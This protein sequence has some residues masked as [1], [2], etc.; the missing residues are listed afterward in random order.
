MSLITLLIVIAIFAAVAAAATYFF[1]K[2]RNIFISLLQYFC[3]FLF[4]VSGFVKAVDPLGTA[5]K[6]EDYF[7]QFEFVARESFLSPI[8]SV[9]PFMAHYSLAFSIFTIVLEIMLGIMLV[10][11]SRPKFTAWTF[12]LLIIFF[13]I[14]TGFTYLTGYVPDDVNFFEFTKWGAYEAS[15]MKV[16]D[17]GCFGDF[18]KLEPRISFFKDIFLL[19]P[20]IIFLF[21]FRDFHR[22]FTP[23]VRTTINFTALA[24]LFIF[25]LY[26]SFWAEPIVDFRPFKNGTNVRDIRAAEMK[27][28]NEVPVTMIIKSKKDGKV[29]RLSQDEY[30]KR[31]K[32]FPKEDFE[33]SQEVGESEIPKTKISDFTIMGLDNDDMTESI[34]DEK[35]YSLMFI[36]YHVPYTE[37]SQQVTV[38][39]TI[40][41]K[42]DSTSTNNDSMTIKNIQS[43]IEN[44]S[45]KEWDPAWV[46]KFKDYI[47]PIME[48][49]QKEDIKSITVFGGVGN[50]DIRDI[51]RVLGKEF[52]VAE[53]DDKLLKT[54]IRSNPGII[55]WKDGRI[56]RKWHVASK[57]TWAKIKPYAK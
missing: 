45:I 53:A 52:S 27:A 25:C 35:G 30:M 2:S 54:M 11:G 6:M 23:I 41:N 34:L 48:S 46:N 3:G 24:G 15:N 32:E 13:T 29:T 4:I 49:A 19:I 39:D 43:K 36:A 37:S 55:L 47:L 10:L 40:Y 5:F 18:I 33:F 7:A 51:E 44:I 28:S 17:C 16:T 1:H 42:S 12:F 56:V 20:A 21:K 38:R 31:F 14:L 22:L 26:N 50:D 9:F 8:A 57:P